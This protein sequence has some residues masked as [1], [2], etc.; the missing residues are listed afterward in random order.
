[1]DGRTREIC[2]I[3]AD[4][5]DVETEESGGMYI[6]DSRKDL[7]FDMRRSEEAEGESNMIGSGRRVAVFGFMASAGLLAMFDAAGC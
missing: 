2:R 6:P 1:M 4:E 3:D 5:V 7:I